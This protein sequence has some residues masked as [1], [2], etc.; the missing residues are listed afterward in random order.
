MNIYDIAREAGVSIAT[1]S[2]VVNGKSVVSGKTRKK[3]EAVLKKYNYTPD[4]TARSLVVKSTK[5]VALLADDVRNPYCGGICH[6]VERE[7]SKIGYTT[8]LCNTGGTVQGI[9]SGLKSALARHAD[10]VLL[11]GMSIVRNDDITAAALN[12]PV[13]VI[14]NYIDAPNVYSVICDEIYGMMLAVSQF[15]SQGRHEI[16][17]VQ[18]SDENSYSTKKLAEGFDAGMAMNDLNSSGRIVFTE[19]G[20]EGG[21]ACAEALLRDAQKF[22]AVV[23]GDDT[24]AAGF[25]KCLKQSYLDVPEDVSVIGFYNTPAAPCV[26]PSL[27][28]VDCRSDKTGAAAVKLLSD[29]FEGVS[30]DKKTVI[31][32]RLVLRDSA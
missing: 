14:N 26:T 8:M 18:D 9:S 25:I 27:S 32:P 15:A 13:I 7:L 28:S 12:V 21:F 11:T 17:Y 16:I 20:F 23:C 1:I 24:T 4:P 19:R 30:V 29:L 2:R 6:T 31:L 5:A 10:A 22:N 3:V